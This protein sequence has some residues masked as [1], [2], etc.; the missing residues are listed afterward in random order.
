MLYLTEE[1]EIKDLIDEMA[2]TKILWLDTE[3]ADYNT[4]K[5]RLS[6]IQILAYPQD[7]NGSRTFI[8]DVLD[9]PILIDY[10]I[11]KIMFNKNIEKVFHNGSYDLIFLG[12]AEAK[13]VT[14]TLKIA[15]EMP[16]YI[17]PI[18]K[19]DLKTLTEKLTDFQ[20]INKEEQGSNWGKRPLTQEQ[21]QY[22][23]MEPVYVAH[24]HQRLLSILKKNNPDPLDEDLDEIGQRYREIEPQWRLLDSE[25]NCL[26]ERA[27]KAMRAQ[28]KAETL[29]FKLSGSDRTKIKVDFAELAQMVI[30][31]GI[32]LHFPITLTKELRAQI[33]D[34]LN[35]LSFTEETITAWRLQSKEATDN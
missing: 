11:S 17:L 35:Q 20:E 18:S 23:K 24:I 9:K 14:C 22:A 28:N 7:I 3:V 4:K 29:V 6:L 16:Y 1:T 2:E 31:E 15:K 25:I 30:R 26:Q 5:P 12:K 34:R 33:G 10:F 32:D 13:N 8:I 21:L 27:K 19:Y